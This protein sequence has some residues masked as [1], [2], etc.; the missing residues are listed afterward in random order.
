MM[1][2]RSLYRTAALL[3]A[4]LTLSGLCACGKRSDDPAL[5]ALKEGLKNAGEKQEAQTEADTDEKA[6][7]NGKDD[8]HAPDASDT[9]N[10]EGLNPE[11][12]DLYGLSDIYVAKRYDDYY[13]DQRDLEVDFKYETFY[14]TDEL[15][16]AYPEL[17]NTLM[18]IND[19]IATEEGHSYRTTLSHLE[20]QSDAE[21]Q[22]AMDAGIFP[23]E[24]EWEIYVRRADEDYVSLVTRHRQA[25]DF[26]Y[27]AY[28][29][30]GCCVDTKTGK[31][32]ELSDFVK[33]EDALFALVGE[34]AYEA[35]APQGGDFVEDGNLIPAQD[36]AKMIRDGL[37][38]DL[39]GWTLDPQGLTFWINSFTATPWSYQVSVL[40][41]EDID[42]RI[43]REECKDLIPERWVM[44]VPL[45]DTTYFDAEDDGKT[46]QIRIYE[47]FDY[48]DDGYRTINA[49]SINFNEDSL[50]EDYAEY[51]AY[52]FNGMLLHFDNRTVLLEQHNEYDDHFMDLYTLNNGKAKYEDY[53]NAYV[54]TLPYELLSDE[55]TV[56]P[57]HI[58]EDPANM[59]LTVYT[60]LLSTCE[61]AGDFSI[62]EEG[63]WVSEDRFYTI[64]ESSRYTITLKMA[65]GEV[66]VVDEDT[67]DIMST[68]V[69]LKAGDKLTMEYTDDK[70][71]V[72]CRTKDGKL[73]RIYVHDDEELYRSIEISGKKHGIYDVFE[74][75]MFAG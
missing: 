35:V 73:V 48:Y 8:E 44:E 23:F 45:I 57:R 53:V 27:D 50:D 2:N 25:S 67:F 33:D 21:H 26:D 39:S 28:S 52:D 24:E 59:H 40:F 46:D 7:E 13:S 64:L 15:K 43:F 68:K 16:S 54:E 47:L 70:S 65:I 49:F 37:Q 29:Y 19:R 61:S 5:D 12:P 71:Y 72:D 32:M 4:V 34:K 74:D 60:N 41:A 18:V 3:L 10:A 20:M 63:K 56:V 51:E 14:I 17:A 55:Y 75:M 6:P 9:G 66:P 69:E 11:A 58:P 31:E 30:V 38:N 62:T 36:L 42:G 22:R 1:K